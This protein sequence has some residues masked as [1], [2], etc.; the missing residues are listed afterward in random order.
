MDSQRRA[1][2]ERAIGREIGRRREEAEISQSGV[3]MCARQFGL[4]WTRATI[5]A[6]ELGRKELT[7]GEL[8]LMPLILKEAGVS[9]APLSLGDLIPTDDRPVEVWPGLQLS[10]P[11]ARTLL[12]GGAETR[13][14]RPVNVGVDIRDLQACDTAEQK[15]ASTLRVP[16]RAIVDA[17]YALWDQSLS[18]ER[19]QRLQRSSA[20]P[21]ATERRRQALK[22]HITRELLDELRPRLKKSKRRSTR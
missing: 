6:I 2:V 11:D 13:E 16:A 4:P 5:A 18:M 3:A 8:L 20:A 17:A 21:G 9:R 14:I 12:T 10:L 19:R 1:T 22:G 7:L 15:A